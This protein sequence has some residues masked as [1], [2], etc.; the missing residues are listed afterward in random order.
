MKSAVKHRITL[1]IKATGLKLIWVG[2]D[3]MLANKEGWYYEGELCDTHELT[4]RWRDATNSIGTDE[5][6]KPEGTLSL[7]N[8]A[9]IWNEDESDYA[10]FP[11]GLANKLRRGTVKEIELWIL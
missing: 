11:E 9:H 5:D 2:S 3:F 4:S 6:G 1:T 7:T 8:E 10:D